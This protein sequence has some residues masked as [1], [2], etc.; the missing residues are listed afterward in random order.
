MKLIIRNL[1][2]L[3]PFLPSSGKTFL[4]VYAVVSSVLSLI[5]IVALM[6]MAL[7][8]AASVTGES[9]ALPLIGSIESDGTVWLILILA[10]IIILKSA[11]NVGLQWIATRRFAAYELAVGQELFGAYIR[12]PWTERI[13]RNSAQIVAMSDTGIAS[14]VAGFLLPITTLPGMI[15]TSL[16]VVAV[17]VFTQ[18]ITAL[19][20][21]VASSR[22]DLRNGCIVEGDHASGQSRRGQRVRQDEPPP[23]VSGAR[24]LQLPL[25]RSAL[26]LRCRR[27][28]RVRGRGRRRDA[29]FRR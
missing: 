20:T 2:R 12:A 15:V 1:R 29:E 5:D 10:A 4:V 28:R 11:A 24:E 23:H 18:P 21:V 7:T 16:G 26:H 9:V 25:D 17:L 13:S 22:P 19:V 14:V 6:L 27:H 8:L 3:I